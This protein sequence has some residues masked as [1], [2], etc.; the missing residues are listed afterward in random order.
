MKN[1][2]LSKSSFIR[3]LQCSKS[4]YLYKHFYGLR[5]K[6]SPETLSKF[7]RGHGVGLLAQ[8]LFPD[9]INLK[10]YSPKQHARSVARTLELILNGTNTLYEAAFSYNNV[11]VFSDIL[12]F[13]N[14]QWHAYEVKSSAEV[15]ETFVM[16]ASLQYYVISNS[17][18]DLAAF[19]IIYINKDYVRQEKLDIMQLFRFKEMLQEAKNNF[20]FVHEKVEEF[21]TLLAN[22]EIPGINIG[23]H[24]NYPYT[25][26]FIGHCWKEIPKRNNIFSIPSLQNEE[27][28]ALY[29]K[30]ICLA[31]EIP[32]ET[33]LTE[34]QKL[35]VGS[36]IK[37]EEYI[38]VTGLKKYFSEIKYPVLI[39]DMQSYRVAVP[40][41]KNS[42]PYQFIPYLLHAELMNE[43]GKEL[44]SYSFFQEDASSH[45]S[46]FYKNIIETFNEASVILIFNRKC[47][48]IALQTLVSDGFLSQ[49]QMETIEKK[50][51]DIE[52]VFYYNLY[53]NPS[54]SLIP[55]LHS[56]ARS[57][58]KMRISR[59]LISSDVVASDIYDSLQSETDMFHVVEIKEKL[60]EYAAFNL[61][62][63]KRFFKYLRSKNPA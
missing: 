36:C 52:S 31:E 54:L 17:G 23:K 41:R 26:D 15:S 57:I 53:F 45:T 58:I 7:S 38:D 32:P 12:H 4:L 8:Q 60:N 11:T 9:G 51:F 37:N 27:K 35:Q 63:L 47:F 28:F 18:I 62:V 25:C 5:D 16:D 3:G 29:N 13:K 21:K 50:T 49:A 22:K 42:K 19:D 33:S 20:P 46:D 56:I 14:N 44:K 59:N 43:E 10:P 1:L 30:G 40:R 55:D 2:N 39:A 34:I 6:L 61:D 24:C 48:L